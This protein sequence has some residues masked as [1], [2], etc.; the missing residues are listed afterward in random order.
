MTTTTAMTTAAHVNA[1]KLRE[2]RASGGNRVYFDDP[3]TYLVEVQN[4]TL[5]AK[6]QGG[7]FF[8][9]E[10]K[11]L[12]T[13]SSK[14]HLQVGARVNTYT[15]NDGSKAAEMYYPNIKNAF[16]AI[17]NLTHADILGMKDEECAVVIESL[18]GQKQGAAGQILL[19]RAVGGT[20]KTGARAGQANCVATYF[21]PSAEDLAKAG[22]KRDANGKPVPLQ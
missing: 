22:L 8:A 11:I 21:Y 10:S 15:P 7:G 20:T 19:V 14:A 9:I 2:T 13:T 5:G 1:A 6:R 16:E 17:L 3:G 18:F 4:V 12:T